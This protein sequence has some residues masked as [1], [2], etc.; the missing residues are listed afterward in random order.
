[1]LKGELP[2]VI[3]E[4]NTG[5]FGNLESAK[6]A[7]RIARKSGASAIK[8]QSFTAESL[9]SNKYLTEN[10]ITKR[11]LSKFSLSPK[12]LR[13]LSDYCSQVEIGFGTTVYSVDEVEAL[14]SLTNLQFVKISSMDFM[15]KKLIRSAT[16]LG[17]PV[18]VSTG[19]SSIRELQ[20]MSDWL[21]TLEAD[22]V[23]LHCVSLYPTP[24]EQT[25]VGNIA[26]LAKL[27]HPFPVGFSDHSLTSNASSAAIALG[28]RVLEKHL[29][30]D[31][32]RPGMDNAMAQNASEFEEYVYLAK[33]I[34]S[35]VSQVDRLLSEEEQNQ[36]VQMRRSAFTIRSMSA[37]EKIMEEDIYFA[38]PGDGIQ[39]QES[40]SL[41]GSIVTEDIASD[42]KVTWS[43]LESQKRKAGEKER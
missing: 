16:L 2:Y 33:K 36:A 9:Y 23:V 34:Y 35:S 14:S 43:K 27:F 18:V 3:C 5:H 32:K 39:V 42:E 20:L 8:F 28:A 19:M 31:K 22:V 29:A 38:R 12:Q 7:V 37:G 6:E 24:E 40:D 13:E 15:N 41:L 26:L 11:M 17:V 30:L 25:N 4:I 1:M 21:R 10:P